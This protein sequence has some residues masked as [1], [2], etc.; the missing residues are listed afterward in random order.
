MFGSSQKETRNRKRVLGLTSALEMA[1][2]DPSRYDVVVDAA[3][4][5]C[6][7]LRGSEVS[8]TMSEKLRVIKS[9]TRA[10]VKAFRG[11]SADDYRTFKTLDAISGDLVRLL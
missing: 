11:G 5:L 1:Y 4:Q 2:E 9:V 8:L 10:K 7:M 3:T 6:S